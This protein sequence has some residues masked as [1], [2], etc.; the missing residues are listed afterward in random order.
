MNLLNN[1]FSKFKK[2]FKTF[3][4]KFSKRYKS[5]KQKIISL[6]LFHKKKSSKKRKSTKTT[7]RVRFDIYRNLS[8]FKN[9]FINSLSNKN[10]RLSANKNKNKNKNNKYK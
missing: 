3:K 5:N 7:S 6:N 4:N 1:T 2:E 9:T 8:N 10:N